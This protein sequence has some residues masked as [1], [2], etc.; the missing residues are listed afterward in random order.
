[1]GRRQPGAAHALVI[2]VCAALG[3][4]C[5]SSTS[6]PPPVTPAPLPDTAESAGPSETTEPEDAPQIAF[7]EKAVNQMNGPVHQC[8]ARG[9]AD[10]FR[11]Q[12]EVVLK[13]TLGE[14]TTAESVEVLSDSTGDAVLV[15]CLTELWKL[16]AWED[17]VF[18]PGDAIQLP[19][20]QFG[21]PRAQFV[22]SS[23]HVAG[24]AMGDAE[25]G[26]SSR[27]RVLL[28]PRNTGNG[29]VSLAMVEMAKGM[30]V[31]LHQHDT[32]EVVYVLAGSGTASGLAKR[33]VPIAA[34]D[35]LYFAPGA[36]HG[37]ESK[38]DLV[39]LIGY[40]PAG[41]EQAM[42]GESYAGTVALKRPGRLRGKRVATAR[43]KAY[44]ILGG[45]GS[46]RIL[47]DAASAADKALSL[48]A[49]TI[50]G[51]A[52]VP[53]HIHDGSTEVLLILEGTG[54]MTI[55][56]EEMPVAAGD[57]I[58]VPSGIEHAFT[59]ESQVKAVQMYTPSG[60]EQRFKGAP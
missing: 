25:P 11:L 14:K 37:F 47:F 45:K 17:A 22:V 53:A 58:Q 44:P 20:F 4:A 46:A 6:A 38:G 55:A 15:G 21:A 13:L 51:G 30:Q 16:Y 7:I 33:P 50:E 24:A 5:G 49:L 60:P 12:G 32:A 2:A 35:G 48:G 9:A 26:K 59:A 18:D 36:A 27:A 39:L 28:H 19:P 34:G 41:P 52:E 8:W 29:A 3:G 10:D 1:M 40:G 54:S 42:L 31:G 23:D 56:G 57:A 43:S